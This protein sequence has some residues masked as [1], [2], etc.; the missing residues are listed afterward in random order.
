M[1]G[2]YQ[3]YSDGELTR[4]VRENDPDAFGELSS[5]YL[6]LIRSRAASFCGPSAPEQEDLIQEGF[7]GLYVAAVSFSEEGGASF[8][9]YAGLCVYRRMVSAA[10]KH[11]SLRNRP[12][13]DSL[14]LDSPAADDLPAEENPEELYEMR[15][16]MQNIFRHLGSALTPLERRALFL[17]VGG[18][19]RSEIPARSGMTLKAF[20]NAMYRVRSKLRDRLK[21][22]ALEG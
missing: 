3:A 2:D 13:N 12:L 8:Q 1:S 10:R 5:R 11:S 21:S 18:C 22:Q 16:R 4:L 20:D 19:K 9:T 6:W 7:L 14:S 15:D 17:Y